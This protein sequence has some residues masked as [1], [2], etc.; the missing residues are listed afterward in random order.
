MIKVGGVDNINYLIAMGD[1]WAQEFAIEDFDVD[2]WREIVRAYSIYVDHRSLCFYDELNKPVG[3]LLGAMTRIPHSGRM[4]GQIH[5]IWLTP[6][7]C[8]NANLYQ[9]H[10]EFETWAQG[11][12]A[13]EITAPDFYPV[14]ETYQDFFQ[15]MGYKTGLPVQ[16][17]GLA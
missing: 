13:Q 7:H 6:D 12:S 4:V 8:T 1:L 17:K 16:I 5:Y 10:S 3:M 9:L 11:F 14:T 2:Q 15:D